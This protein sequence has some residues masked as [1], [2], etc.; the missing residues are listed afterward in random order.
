MATCV[1]VW[2]GGAL[3]LL[4]IL[5]TVGDVIARV[6]FA[7]GYIGLVDVTQFAVVGFAYLGMPFAFWRRR[8]VAIE[9]YDHLLGPRSDAVL[10]LLGAALAC[11]VLILLLTYGWTQAMR[12]LRYGDVS[13]NA[14]IPMIAFWVLV[15][16]GAAISSLIVTI[17]ALTAVGDLLMRRG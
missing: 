14:E 1:L 17:Q 11:T 9:L 12:T 16:S 6:L 10:R 5:L 3:L 15:L 7:T 2:V 8:H 13:Q 4:A